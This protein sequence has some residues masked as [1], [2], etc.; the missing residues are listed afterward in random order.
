MQRIAKTKTDFVCLSI[1]APTLPLVACLD[2]QIPP[3]KEEHNH[4]NDGGMYR[5]SD[6]TITM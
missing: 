1:G 4:Q 5:S 6:P 2:D 3:R